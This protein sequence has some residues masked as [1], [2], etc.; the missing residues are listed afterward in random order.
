M[1]AS[2]CGALGI[3]ISVPFCRSKCTY[4]NFASGVYPASEH[5][6]YIDRLVAD[7]AAAPARAGQTGVELP[8]RV[9]TV[10]LGGGTPSMLAPELVTRLFNSLRA[11]FNIQS[12]AEI[13]IECAPGQISEETLAALASSG[14]NRVSLGVQS[15]IDREAAVSGRLHNRAVVLQDIDRLRQAGIQNINVDLIAGLAGQTFASWDESL[16]VLAECG[17][18]HAS[19]YMLEVDQDSRLGRELLAH[20][21]RYHA[22]IV[23][24]D[25]AIA[26]MYERAIEALKQADLEQYEISNFCQPGMASRHNL[27]YWQRRPYLG[28]GLDAS[29]MFYAASQVQTSA[30][31]QGTTS[32]VPQVAN[33]DSGFSRCEMRRTE[34]SNAGARAQHS[35]VAPTARLKSCPDTKPESLERFSASRNASDANSRVLRTTTSDELAAF[36]QDSKPVEDS[37]LTPAQQHEEAW[38]LGLRLNKGVVIAEIEQEFGAA[39]IA[40]ALQVVERLVEE[41]LLFVENGNVRL[42]AQGRLLSN[43]VF[44]EFL[45]D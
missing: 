39:V 17:V 18:P 44:Q 11:V 40:P 21:A 24:S 10:Y 2:D 42:T 36:M 3:Y 9:D 43:N 6:R 25:D 34:N 45:E 8:R 13:T 29:S 7:I 4:C 20:G 38:F 37:W 41:G 32:V 28:L 12:D 22:D 23:P 33:I 19:V 27:R 14:V 26:Q 1:V 15:F 30:L 16:A 31:Y 5:A 35:F